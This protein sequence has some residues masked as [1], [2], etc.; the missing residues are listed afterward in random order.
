M[1]TSTLSLANLTQETRAPF[2]L[3]ICSASFEDRSLSVPMAIGRQ[4][5]CILAYNEDYFSVLSDNLST[6]KTA[7]PNTLVCNMRADDPLQTADAISRNIDLAW[8]DAGQNQTIRIAVDITTFTRESLLMLMRYIW[9]RMDHRHRLV[10]Y[11]IRAR[12]Y[13]VG[14]D[15]TKKWLSSGIREVRSVVG[16]PGTFLPSRQNHLILMTGF[17][18]VRALRL[19]S[20]WEP[21]V[22][23]LGVADSADRD[24]AEH[25]HINEERRRRV[26]NVFGPVRHFLFSAYDPFRARMSLESQAA[27]SSTMNTLIAPMNTKIATV[28][29]A[30]AACRNPD[31]QLCYAQADLYNYRGYSTPGDTVYV[32]CIQK[33]DLEVSAKDGPPG[34]LRLVSA[35]C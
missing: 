5:P 9:L 28:G 11:Y 1:K 18:D 35:V 27:V 32:V 19:V 34:C 16:Y 3:F 22:L 29:A 17:E 21:S 31:I 10:L 33:S 6:L 25:Q 23:S 20:E 2:D 7:F 4:E 24:T 12:E 14:V 26:Q 15:D 13:S 8:P 30:L